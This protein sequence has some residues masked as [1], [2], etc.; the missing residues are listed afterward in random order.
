MSSEF[1]QEK[2]T[3]WA[4]AALEKDFSEEFLF[5]KRAKELHEKLYGRERL[6]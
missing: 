2:D 6:S 4:G 3:V 5:Q 1:M